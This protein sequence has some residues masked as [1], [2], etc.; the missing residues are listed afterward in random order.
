MNH[1]TVTVIN[2]HVTVIIKTVM[3]VCVCA[4][5]P[6]RVYVRACAVH[7]CMRAYMHACVRE[8]EGVYV[9]DYYD[10]ERLILGWSIDIII[11]PDLIHCSPTSFSQSCM[12]LM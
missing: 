2:L 9:T 8:K 3:C 4:C 12:N 5:T 1:M 6:R 11:M 10:I 7:A